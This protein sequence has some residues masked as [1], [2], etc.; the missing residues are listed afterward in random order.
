MEY[1][2]HKISDTDK[3]TLADHLNGTAQR[4]ADFAIPEL[5]EIAGTAGRLHDMIDGVIDIGTYREAM[6]C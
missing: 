3:Q 1:Y 2:A 4:A 5:S 6:L